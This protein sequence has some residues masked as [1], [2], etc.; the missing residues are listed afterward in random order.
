MKMN[1]LL[2]LAIAL[3]FTGQIHAQNTANLTAGAANDAAC[4]AT[5]CLTIPVGNAGG[6]SFSLTGTF[7]GTLTFE[8]SGNDGASYSTLLVTPTN[9]TTAVTTTTAAGTWQANVAG[10]SYVRIRF[11]TYSSGTVAAKINSSVASARANG[12]GGGSGGTGCVP[13]GSSGQVLID[14]GAGACSDATNLTDA[15]AVFATSPGAGVAHFAGGT[16]G[17]TSSAVTPSD[18]TG[19]TTGSGNFV[20][21]TSATLVTPVLGTP[22]SGVAT[23]ITGLPEGGLSLT[24]ITTNNASTSKHGFLLK[25]DNN[26][27][28]FMNGQGAW[29]TPAGGGSGCTTSG[30]AGQVLTDDGAG[31]C[32]SNSSLTISGGNVSTTGTLSAGGAAGAAGAFRPL[33][34]TA[35]GHATAS[36]IVVEAPAAVTA[37]EL[38][39]PGS[40]STGFL[41]GTD[42]SNVNTITN[43]GSSGSGN[44]VRVTS[45]TLVTPTLGAATATS[46]TSATYLTTTKC[47][48]VGTGASPSVVSCSAA[49]SGSFSCATNASTATCTINTSAMTANS[50]VF[51]QPDASLGTLLSVTC[52]TTADT[53]LTA[54]RVSARAGGTSFTINLGTFATNP[55]CFNYWIAN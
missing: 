22:A 2:S 7:S 20:L 5:S 8:A 16:Q 32:A 47:A 28:H 36:T 53:G 27:A 13:A 41:L 6:A 24:D 48:A 15:N 33:A 43:V 14:S 34:G 50:A 37:Y 9:S 40:S 30:S 38:V 21:A 26:S 35:N 11:S 52:N 17:A 31:G 18:A 12:G 49:P 54:P 10:Y 45:P 44:V 55:L 19:N 1:W 46:V 51:V 29:A 23:N 39:L 25:L 4:A 42:A 3:L